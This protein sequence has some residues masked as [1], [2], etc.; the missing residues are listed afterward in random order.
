MRLGMAVVSRWSEVG[1]KSFASVIVLI[2]VS[3]DACRS[4]SI[5]CG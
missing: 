1:V 4:G 3:K 5:A 2:T